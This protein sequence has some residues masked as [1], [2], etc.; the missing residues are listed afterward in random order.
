MN[1]ICTNKCGSHSLSSTE[2]RHNTRTHNAMRYTQT[3]MGKGTSTDQLGFDRPMVS[4]S[5]SHLW[6]TCW[7]VSQYLI[8]LWFASFHKP[9]T[10]IS[11]NQTHLE[12]CAFHS[13]VLSYGSLVSDFQQT[14]N[15]DKFCPKLE[16][17]GEQSVA[18]SRTICR[19]FLL[20]PENFPSSVH[21]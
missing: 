1:H 14:Q 15:Q 17:S 11:I 2:T 9:W 18:S 7:F 4:P 5:Q 12:S 19:S 10:W 3:H 20:S 13:K 21:L 6:H 8:S 16:V